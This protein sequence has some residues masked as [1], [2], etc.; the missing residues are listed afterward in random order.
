[1]VK[2]PKGEMACSCLG[3]RSKGSCSHSTAVN[4][5]TGKMKVR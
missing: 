3:Y 2:T 4:I 1:V 5:R